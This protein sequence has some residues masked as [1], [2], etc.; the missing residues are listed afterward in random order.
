MNSI[1]IKNL[2][3]VYKLYRSP[4]DRLKE[5]VTGKKHHRDFSALNDVSFN[6]EKGQ[7]VGIIGRNGSGKSTLL[8]IIC[9]V[10]QPTGGSV[11]VNGRIS[12]LLELGAGFNPAFNGRENVYMNGALMGF[13]R[14]EMDQR[15]PDIEAFADIGEFIEQPVKTYSSGMQIRLA[16]AAAINVDPDILVVDE[17]LAVGDMNFKAKCMTAFTHIQKNGATILF[18]SHDTGSV[19]SLCSR[20]IYL[21]HGKVMAA[22]PAAEVVEKY[23]RVMREEMNEEHGKSIRVSPTVTS[24]LQG[25]HAALEIGSEAEFKTS[26]EFTRRVAQFR[27]GTGEVKV[28]CVELLNLNDE[29]VDSVEFNQQIRIR[30]FF[31][32]FAK[33][34]ISVNV[35]V[36]DEKKNNIVGCGFPHADHPW[37]DT[38]TGGKY[39][40]EY[41][42]KLPLQ[43]GNY[44]LRIQITEPAVPDHGAVFIDVV[45]DAVVFRIN[46]WEKARVWSKVHLF[47]ELNLKQLKNDNA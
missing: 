10:L 11:K 16:F 12:S 13:S 8:K 7:T 20:G 29:P 31:E 17:A 44:S 5:I 47:P 4:K 39:V 46:R 38:N 36:L 9:G 30:V 6:V 3:K 25:N 45:N 42:F 37:L 21:E 22:G 26:E 15:L 27:Y 18:V 34:T 2:S 35:N 28:T 19:K 32:A 23:I 33:K 41:T 14:K 24:E 43:D 40:A 1:E